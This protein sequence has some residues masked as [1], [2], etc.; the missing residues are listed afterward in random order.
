MADLLN[1]KKI[2]II[3]G[4]G[5]A[6]YKCLD[7]I[8]RLKE[9]GAN[10]QAILTKGGAE[11]ITPL[12]ISS[13]SENKV[14]QDLFSLTDEAEMGHI[15]LSRENDLI[16]VAPATADL[17][18]KMAMG[19]ADN[20]A[21]T[22]LLAANKPVM[23]APTMNSQMWANPATQQNLKTLQ[24]RNILVIPP[25]D[26][27]LAC[28]EVGTG[29]LADVDDIISNL[30][31]FFLS[32]LQ[33]NPLKN[34]KITVTAGPTLEAIDP[35]RYI[36]NHSSGKQGYAIA[37]ALRERGAIVTLISGPTHLPTPHGVMRITVKSAQEMLKATEKT[38]PADGVICVAA[39][40]DWKIE[41]PS[42]QKIK[43]Q[44]G[45]L[46]QLKLSENP[47]ILK[48]IS[49]HKKYRPALVVGFAAETD[50]LIEY[51]QNKLTKKGCDWIIANDISGDI[52][53]GD[54]NQVH[55][56]TKEGVEHWPLQSKL[57]VARQLTKQ[58]EEYFK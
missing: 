8:R 53:G 7:L 44:K 52:M 29:R 1:H 50:H 56:V 32:Q 30:E 31:D 35:V 40:T 24:Q 28:G 46:P 26:G 3:I 41:N 17:M 38:L 11:F 33:N 25:A 19:I 36:A 10:V 20:L 51:A 12:S 15:R 22:T 58:I 13:L 37:Q 55:L 9:R 34:K 39:V 42:T 27:D 14:Y 49:T 6:A 4:G 2:L 57:D 45:S 47:D 16:L 18:A 43:K 23:I 54:E 21:T 48:T 5:I